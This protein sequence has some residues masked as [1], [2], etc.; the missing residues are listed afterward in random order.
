VRQT[1]EALLKGAGRLREIG[2]EQVIGTQLD[3]CAF[4]QREP[5]A[6]N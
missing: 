5:G 6:D 3:G 1:A 4:R 2:R